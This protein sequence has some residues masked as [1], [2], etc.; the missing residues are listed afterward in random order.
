MLKKHTILF[1][2]AFCLPFISLAQ[3]KQASKTSV[4][5]ITRCFTTER[6]QKMMLYSPQ[7]KTSKQQNISK[8]NAKP[9]GNIVN[10]AYN[11][12]GVIN[13]PVVF[14][15]VLTNPYIVTDAVVQSQLN[16]LNTDFAGINADSTNAAGFYSVR[17]HSLKIKF[18][19][20]K[21]T[22][23]GLLTNGI[24]RVKSNTVS[25]ANA[26]IDPIKRTSLG[27]ADVWDPSSYLNYWISDG[28]KVDGQVILGYAQFPGTGIP[29]DDG[30][31]C[32]INSFGVSAC[33]YSD[34][35][36][37]RTLGHETGHYLG[38][39]HIWG[40]EDACSGDDFRPLAGNIGA[41]ST[42]ILP[43]TL[44]NNS[45]QGNTSTDI[46]DTPNQGGSTS[47]CPTSVKTDACSSKSPGTMYQNYMDYTADN[48]Y[49][50]FTKRQV[51]RMEW[52]VDNAR[53]G[54]ATSLGGT[55]P[56]G[57]ITLDAAPLEPVNPG[58]MEASG[59]TSIIYPAALNCPGTIIPKVRIINNGTVSLTS[60]QVGLSVNGIVQA[61]VTLAFAAPG[62]ATGATA[63]VSFA[64]ITAIAG[65]NTLKFY[66]Y[67][68]NG[69]TADL[70]PAND[71]LTTNLPIS[72]GA[73]LP[74]LETFENLPFP[75][76]NWF[77]YNP[78]GDVSFWNRSSPGKNSGFA[79]KIDNFT[80]GNAGSIDEI[81]TP[82][83]LISAA[84]PVV[85][86]FD[87]AYKNYPPFVDKLTV[88]VS[89]D[90]GTNWTA[91][92]DKAGTSLAT[93]GSSTVSYDNPVEA[94]WQH[95]Q[96]AIP[97]NLLAGGQILIAFRNTSD[98]GNNIFIDNINIYQQPD[99]DLLPAAVLSPT[100]IECSATIGAPAVTIRNSGL[101]AVTGFTVGYSL[102][103]AAFVGKNFTQIINAGDTA[104]VLLDP[105]TGTP[106]DNSL[107]ILT[108]NPISISGTG[109]QKPTNDTLKYTFTIAKVI[110][111]PVTEGF[112]NPIF[113][114][115]N[116]EIV[117]PGHNNTWV[118]VAS[119][120]NSGHSAFIDNFSNDFT[121]EPDA[122]KSAGINVAGADSV[123]IT[124]DLAHKFRQG[125]S[126]Q[127]KVNVS[128][129]CGNTYTAIFDK[130]GQ[131]L[132][133]AGESAVAY[134]SPAASDW[135]TQ[136]IA[137]GGNYLTSG[138]IVVAFENIGAFGN[139]IFI[140]NINI[141]KFYKRDIQLLSV[142]QPAAVLCNPGPIVPAVIIKNMGNDTI[143]GYKVGY[144]I[145]NGPLLIKTITGVAVAKGNQA[146]TSLDAFNTTIGSHTFTAFSFEP[147]SSS[148]VGDQDTKN[149]SVATTFAVTGMQPTLPLAEG[150]E[151]ATFPPTNWGIVNPDNATTWQRTTVAAKTGVGA[152][153]INNFTYAGSAT[154]TIDK[155]VSPLITNS[156][157]NDTLYTSFDLAYAPGLTNPDPTIM[158]FDTLEV[159]V[160]KDCGV[161]MQTA[162][163]KWGAN[164]QTVTDS[165]Y[166]ATIGYT[167]VTS[168]WKH[169]NVDITPF[170]G[171][172]NFQVYFVAK[173]NRQ[174]NIWLDNVTIYS[175]VLPPKLKEQGYLIYPN[176]FRST[177]LIH[178]YHVPTDLKGAQVFNSAGQ[179]VWAYN[180]QGN[181]V[182]EI[183]VDLSGKAKG[184]YIL[185]LT[186]NDRSVQQKII[187]Y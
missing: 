1:L 114:P 75:A 126:N 155:F 123:V 66:T 3:K 112:E 79:I 74:M 97:Q 106:G 117:N 24:D 16:E 92:F 15:I 36:K 177:F 158:M 46:G 173:G 91:V 9:G 23:V 187:K 58:G 142:I 125:V 176:P 88:L 17:G 41:N 131:A 154:S 120:S 143:T 30:V 175:K 110:E 19:L 180:Y 183:T 94:D 135:A 78:D 70:V 164:L 149:D 118:R 90:C 82:K 61:P 132:A 101:Q 72:N 85:V 22:P 161:T 150:F 172:D 83:F 8:A 134:V 20:A 47:G 50:M 45:A 107:V 33:N 115:L 171:T 69:N 102:N 139:N 84:E 113:P 153:V 29:E 65:V 42:V 37:G 67:G 128:S 81:R 140:D 103:G 109:D 4:S 168:E 40:D 13:I 12:E 51:Q 53:T 59:C 185:K 52:I 147:V 145:D 169:I 98:F 162:W 32:N 111:T 156:S 121:G 57:A 182:T 116:W 43:D 100:A 77:V 184:V 174:N 68:A 18:V 71:T 146:A 38:L 124:F 54:L 26:N 159:Q 6:L 39:F 95:Q 104:T 152:M 73:P 105:F 60:L 35:N 28:I 7:Q 96:I 93:A 133:T 80:D 122:I 25:D 86:S 21:R 186:Y 108:S 138:N 76:T 56:T 148:G 137:I 181:A 178:H 127:L 48:C 11:T 64:T 165:N 160:T 31:F 170:V 55:A 10:R 87:L 151:G 144:S 136:K 27:G 62:L 166:S 129:D 5:N 63:V 130:A 167:P 44:A 163:K 157:A 179:L 14:H 119:G 2:F 99:R 49:S 89:N 34:Y 141:T